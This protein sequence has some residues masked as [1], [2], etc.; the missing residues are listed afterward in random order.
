MKFIRMCM[1]FTPQPPV[2]RIITCNQR[3]LIHPFGCDPPS[4]CEPS[5]QAVDHLVCGLCILKRRSAN[6]LPCGS[7]VMFAIVSVFKS[8]VW[9]ASSKKVSPY[10]HVAWSASPSSGSECV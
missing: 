7:I 10:N 2:L 6:V 3:G 1:P 9:Y 4:A 8:M 5:T